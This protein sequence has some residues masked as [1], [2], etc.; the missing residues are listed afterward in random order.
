MRKAAYQSLGPFIST[1]Y[2]PNSES[3]SLENVSLDPL[4]DSMLLDNSLLE[5][6]A[7]TTT[8]NSSTEDSSSDNRH[9]LPNPPDASFSNSS[10][11]IHSNNGAGSSTAA[12]SQKGAESDS[13]FSDFEFQRSPIPKD[14]DRRDEKIV[15][16]VQDMS[17]EDLEDSL[18][19]EL[20][21]GSQEGEKLTKEELKLGGGDGLKEG[22][23]QGR[24]NFDTVTE[25]HQDSADQGKE[26]VGGGATASQVE[27]KTTSSENQSKSQELQRLLRESQDVVEESRD[28]KGDKST[29]SEVSSTKDNEQSS[30][31]K[32]KPESTQ[33]K[34][35]HRT[36][37]PDSSSEKAAVV[38]SPV[39]SSKSDTSEVRVVSSTTSNSPPSPEHAPNASKTTADD[40]SRPRGTDVAVTPDDAMRVRSCSAGSSLRSELGSNLVFGDGGRKGPG[41][42]RKRRWSLDKMN[43]LQDN[44]TLPP[45]SEGSGWSMCIVCVCVCVCECVCVLIG[46]GWD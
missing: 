46:V 29:D 16:G 37:A 18:R 30:S 31:T 11:P 25:S 36:T 3:P 45:V 32:Q 24:L 2:V 23:V 38:S 4:G 28:G 7:L 44:N 8:G 33:S 10:T 12:S 39:T 35:E 42:T 19:I 9:P 20:D 1:F 27:G 14:G 22:D 6:S 15:G 40:E 34:G 13:L 5:S 26:K 43:K 41:E 21:A 17:L